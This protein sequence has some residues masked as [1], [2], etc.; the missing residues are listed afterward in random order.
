MNDEQAHNPN[1]HHPNRQAE[2]GDLVLVRMLDRLGEVE[3]SEAGE[4]FESRVLAS[5]RGVDAVCEAMDR[6]G[7]QERSGVDEGFEGRLMDT[8]GAAMAPG[9]IPIAHGNRTAGIGSRVVRIRLAAGLLLAGSVG[10]L[11]WA[12]LRATGPELE[13]V[14]GT[15]AI[16]RTSAEVIER[17]LDLLWELVESDVGMLVAE[18]DVG[19]GVGEF[20]A[21]M[22]DLALDL[23]RVDSELDSGWGSLDSWVESLEEGAI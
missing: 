5:V 6:L 16:E 9:P 22:D 11:T 12:G 15:V 18:R 17:D 19:V 13:G 10:V 8:V 2:S 3:R 4:G 14:E 7:A 23:L 20:D 1:P 21:A